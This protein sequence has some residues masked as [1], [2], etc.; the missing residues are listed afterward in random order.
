MSAAIAAAD[1][2]ASVL[3]VEEEYDLGGFLRFEPKSRQ[4]LTELRRAVA[5][6][7]GIEVLTNSVVTGRYD[8]NW[9]AIVQRGLPGIHER[10]VKARAKNLV[11]APGLIERPF[12]FEGNDLPGVMLSTGVRRLINLWAVKPGTWAVVMTANDSGDEA[13]ADLERAGVLVRRVVDARRGDCD[14][15]GGRRQEGRSLGRTEERGAHR[16]RPGSDR[17]RMDR[18]HVASQHGRGSTRLRPGTAARFFP[19][20]LPDNVMVAGSIAGDGTTE[21]LIDHAA[22]TGRE[23]ARRALPGGS[24][25]AV[26]APLGG[27]GR[28][29][30]RFLP[31]VE[32][33]TSAAPCSSR[34]VSVVDP[35]DGRFQ[36]RR[37]I[38]GHPRRQRGGL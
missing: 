11:V 2:G 15:P 24:D 25:L 37:V 26:D 30:T 34:T 38:E 4:A 12:V 6:R 13:V 5:T 3:L 7:P 36:R 9:V 21:E 22:A 16:L 33:N 17:D 23:A 8:D 10:L 14:R 32:I 35:R 20:Q 18:S 27:S 1:A 31:P 29:R 28:R 19:S